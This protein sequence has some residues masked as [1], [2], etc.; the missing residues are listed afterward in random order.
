MLRGR[1]DGHEEP[2]PTPNKMKSKITGRIPGM[3]RRTSSHFVGLSFRQVPKIRDD[4]LD[5]RKQT[6]SW[7]VVSLSTT[8]AQKRTVS[9]PL[10]Q[11]KNSCIPPF[12]VPKTP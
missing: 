8:K 11:A 9:H 1:D 5:T 12:L 2:H 4:N 10:A 3:S 6:P 7:H